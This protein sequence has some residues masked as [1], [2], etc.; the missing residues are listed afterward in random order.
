MKKIL[1]LS[2][3]DYATE[4]HGKSMV[5]NGI[6]NILDS[7]EGVDLRVI[8][9]GTNLPKIENHPLPQLGSIIRSFLRNIFNHKTIQSILYY[10]DEFHRDFHKIIEEVQPDIIIYDTMR[11]AQFANGLK[12]SARQIVYMD[13]LYSKRYQRIISFMKENNSNINL[14]GNFSKKLPSILKRISQSYLIQ[15]LLVNYEISAL[16]KEE[17]E[18]VDLYDKV[19]LIS[20]VEVTELAELTSKKNI[21]SIR[22]LI[23]DGSIRRA[24]RENGRFIFLGDLSL[25]HNEASIYNFLEENTASILQINKDIEVVIIGKGASER[26]LKYSQKYP[27]NII[28]LGYVEDISQEFEQASAMIAPLI[29]GSGVKIKIIEAMA[30]S[31]PIIATSV[32]LEGVYFDNKSSGVFKATPKEFTSHMRYLMYPSNSI[33]ESERIANQFSKHYSLDK[34]EEEYRSVFLEEMK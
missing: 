31:L 7:L 29:F 6:V 32:A 19:V 15:R 18:S 24:P 4:K 8:G 25:P 1:F 17:R 28:I 21:E 27:K 20:S 33:M 13:D 10:S 9:L 3:T 23:K 11:T 5:I 14:M 34:V 22:P 30:N 12:T 26:L 2:C 16:R